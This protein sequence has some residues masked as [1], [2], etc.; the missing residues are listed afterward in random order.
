MIPKGIQNA[1]AI[2]EACKGVLAKND[3]SAGSQQ[4]EILESIV[5]VIGDLKSKFFI[6]TNLAVPATN[7]C[8]KDAIELEQLA[9][10]G[11]LSRFPGALEQLKTD[12]EKLLKSAKMDG[13]I[14]T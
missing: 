7:A 1:D 9:S 2:I 14:I 8:R 5:S 6:K 3:N 11:D 4:R 10:G 13:I 12:V